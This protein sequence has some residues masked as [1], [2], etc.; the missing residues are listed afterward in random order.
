M[1]RNNSFPFPHCLVFDRTCSCVCLV[2]VEANARVDSRMDTVRLGI[3]LPHELAASFYHFRSGDLFYSLLTGTPEDSWLQRPISSTW[4]NQEAFGNIIISMFSC[5]VEHP[6]FGAM[7]KQGTP[8]LNNVKQWFSGC[9][10]FMS[11]KPFDLKKNKP[12]IKCYIG[13]APFLDKPENMHL[14]RKHPRIL[15]NTGSTT[16]TCHRAI[17]PGYSLIDS[18]EMAQRLL[19]S[20]ISSC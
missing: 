20:T 12:F 7:V 16:W 6:S 1:W 15:P 9:Q 14:C 17:H 4:L 5:S 8:L 13:G 18:M 3:I 11:T 10:P 2:L 19:A